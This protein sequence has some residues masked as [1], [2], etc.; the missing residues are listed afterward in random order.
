MTRALVIVTVAL[1]AASLGASAQEHT[2]ANPGNNVA[3]QD[4]VQ[5]TQPAQ[6]SSSFGAPPA[7]AHAQ[8]AATS[9]PNGRIQSEDP[10][11]DDSPNR[12]QLPQTSTILPLLGLIG[13]GSLLAGLFARR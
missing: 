2:A 8:N 6:Q 11:D 10:A 9:N 12:A 5:S 13:L 7:P 1:A 3:I 4:S